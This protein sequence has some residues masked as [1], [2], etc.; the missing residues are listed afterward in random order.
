MTSRN[1]LTKCVDYAPCLQDHMRRAAKP[2]YTDVRSDRD[3][4]PVGIVEFE[5]YDDM[6]LAIRKLDDSEFDNP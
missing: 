5:T 2:L 6:K 3:G 1:R 4:K